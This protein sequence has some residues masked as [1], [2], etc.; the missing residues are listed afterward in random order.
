MKAVLI[1]GPLQDGTRSAMKE[2][3]KLA[4]L[5]KEQGVA[6]QTFYDN[7]AKW[8][9]IK[10][11]AKG[12]HFFVYSGHG[13]YGGEGGTAGGLCIKEWVFAETLIEELEL[14]PGALVIFKSV[15]MGAGSSAGD[16]G[17][18]SLEEATTRVADYSS[19]FFKAGAGCYYAN[20]LGDGCYDFLDDFFE[21]K[22]VQECFETSAKTWAKIES[23]HKMAPGDERYLGIASIDWGG[24]STLTTYTNGVKKVRQVKNSKSYSI[25]Y[26]GKPSYSI[27]ALRQIN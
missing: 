8:D 4:A 9:L 16:R 12:A 6:T 15:C 13:I 14:H 17:A 10:T 5:F 19:A 25:A 20:N 1:V 23:H 26:V 7:G 27:S 11:A 2:M 21:G 24:K 18:I 22:P 3:D